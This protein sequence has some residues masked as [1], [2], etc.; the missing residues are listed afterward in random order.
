MNFKSSFTE[1]TCFFVLL[2]SFLR[3]EPA[4]PL[5]P[6]LLSAK[7]FFPSDSPIYGGVGI[8]L[9]WRKPPSSLV[10][11]TLHTHWL[12]TTPPHPPAPA[13][14]VSVANPIPESPS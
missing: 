5:A 6:Q 7:R 11:F 4:Q 2:C 8:S 10:H 12:E 14:A 13:W 1:F 3:Q 9:A